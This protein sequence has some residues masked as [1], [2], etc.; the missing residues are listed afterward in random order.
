M[1][2]AVKQL[3]DFGSSVTELGG[4]ILAATAKPTVEEAMA[5]TAATTGAMVQVLEKSFTA[6]IKEYK[7]PTVN[8]AS[9]SL[10]SRMENS[11]LIRAIKN[12]SP[13]WL[14]ATELLAAIKEIG[15]NGKAVAN[16]K[17]DDLKAFFVE[18]SC[19]AIRANVLIAEIRSWSQMDL[20]D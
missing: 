10:L 15:L 6:C 2:S 17:D 20:K 12:I 4:K 18:S 3:L 1:V 5:R 16:M 9:N 8:S 13:Y 19:P 11:D 14:A 7:K